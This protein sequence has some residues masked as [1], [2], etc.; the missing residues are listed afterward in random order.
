MSKQLLQRVRLDDTS[1]YIRLRSR[2][3]ERKNVDNH[4]PPLSALPFKSGLSWCVALF[5]GA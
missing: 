5:G 2:L 3:T 1:A 4:R